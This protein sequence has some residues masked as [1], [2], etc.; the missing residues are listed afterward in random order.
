MASEKN[1]IG[2]FKGL[3]KDFLSSQYSKILFLAQKE[4]MDTEL[5]IAQMQGK[6]FLSCFAGDVGHC[7][8]E[9]DPKETAYNCHLVLKRFKLPMSMED[10]K[11]QKEVGIGFFNNNVKN[12]SKV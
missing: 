4:R 8:M 5:T 12:Y 9:D 6:F 7:M 2:W 1:W 11:R 3:T 10:V